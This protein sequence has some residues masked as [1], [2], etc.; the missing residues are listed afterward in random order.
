MATEGRRRAYGQHFLKDKLVCAR[1]S[2]T[3]VALAVEHECVAVLEVGPGKG[4]LTFPLLECLHQVSGGSSKIKELILAER[5]P[6][7]V[8]FWRE[9]IDREQRFP[10]RVVE[11][12]FANTEETPELRWK[13]GVPL[14]VVSNLPYSAGT[15]ILSRLAELRSEIPVMVL[16]FQA[17]VAQRIRAEP[18]TRAWGSLSLAVQN[19]WDV[20]RL[21][22]VPPGAFSPPPEVQSEVVVLKARKHLRISGTETE[23]GKKRFEKLVKACFAHRR[24]MIRSSLARHPEFL[25]ALERAS[26]R[27]DLRAEA[28]S[29]EQWNLWFQNLDS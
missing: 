7:L 13:R 18:D 17:E 4:A 3:A 26:I 1:I 22:Q 2:E 11:G 24:K 27:S 8:A 28:L 29:W 25:S 14:A 12:D 16:M 15:A 9:L 5:D 20:T 21:L 19:A 10:F 23:A 6:K